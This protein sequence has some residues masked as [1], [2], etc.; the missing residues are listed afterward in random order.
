MRNYSRP[1]SVL[2]C[3]LAVSFAGA[4]E[5]IDLRQAIQ[6]AVENNPRMQV[7]LKNKAVA[8]ADVAV[9]REFSNPSLIGETTRSQPNYFA[10]AGYT[11]EL[12]GKRGKRIDIALS[13]AE[14]AQL[15]YR[16]GL[17][18]LRHDVRAAFFGLLFSRSKQQEAAAS[19]DMAQR[20]LDISQQRFEAGDAPRLEALTAQLALKQRENE[21]KQADADAKAAQ[22][23]L[24]SLLNRSP[25]QDLQL[26]GSLE[27]A[28]QAQP[29]DSLVEQAMQQHLDVQSLQQQIKGEEA[30]LSL[31]HAGRI[32]DLEAEG[33][34]EIHD[35]DFQ[36][37]WRA[38]LRFEL[39]LLNQKDGEIQR[40]TAAMEA[41]QAQLQVAVQ[42][43][44]TDISAAYLKYESA[45]F[46]TDNYRKEILP[47]TAE[48]E[49]LAEESYKE[50]RTGILGVLEAQRAT[51]QVRLDYLDVLLQYQTAIADLELASGVELP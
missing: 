24:N 41:L 6:I 28:S 10:G 12:G 4:Q 25:M 44:R 5:S 49:T 7:F 27:E 8:D 32:P 42:R 47:E 19:R 26:K 43:I 50:G 3:L 51:R 16:S 14:V 39:P 34:A 23:Q 30:R 20:L 29:L 48:I 33:G 45:S 13:A 9:A 37:G 17:L 35:A 22:L 11:F 2:L 21:L 46:Q 1:L 31:A 18:A 36:Y 38:A 15:E 40:S